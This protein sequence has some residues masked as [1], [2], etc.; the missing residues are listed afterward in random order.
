MTSK[1]LKSLVK[2]KPVMGELGDISENAFEL[3][4]KNTLH[5]CTLLN[6]VIEVR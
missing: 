4:Q 2:G 5:T 6:R 3:F 1:M